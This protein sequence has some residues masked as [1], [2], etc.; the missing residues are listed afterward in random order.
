MGLLADRRDPWR[1]GRLRP[2]ALRDSGNEDGL[3]RQNYSFEK[4]MR[5]QEKQKKKQ[6]KLAKKAS[7]G[8]EGDT[9]QGQ[10]VAPE[11]AA[12]GGEGGPAPE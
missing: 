2:Q 3:A 1:L 12:E 10:D 4:R 6:E 9:P 7:K 8:P 11:G 5:E